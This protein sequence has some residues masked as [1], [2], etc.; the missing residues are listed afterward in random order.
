[1]QTNKHPEATNIGLLLGLAVALAILVAGGL[2]LREY[3][4]GNMGNGFL[5]GGSVALVGFAI[6]AWRVRRARNTTTLE[7]AITQGGDER[8]DAVLTRALAVLGAVGLPL[9]GVA[10]IAIALGGEVPVVLA[11]LLFAQLA[12]GAGAFATINHRS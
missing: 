11:M 3:G 1:M 5:W 12:V 8:D 10:A 2:L 4:P 9:T 6:A 7:R